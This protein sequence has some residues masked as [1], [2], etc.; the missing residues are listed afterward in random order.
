MTVSSESLLAGNKAVTRRKRAPGFRGESSWKVIARKS[1]DLL[2]ALGHRRSRFLD[3]MLRLV[4][5][6]TY[7]RKILQD[8]QIRNYLMEHHRETLKKIES[9]LG[10]LQRQSEAA[11][12]EA[13]SMWTVAQ[14]KK[15]LQTLISN[16]RNEG[17]QV[18]GHGK[19]PLVV[20]ISARAWKSVLRHHPELKAEL[21]QPPGNSAAP[22][23][24][25]NSTAKIRPAAS[26]AGD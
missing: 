1:E 17:P 7:F 4:S 5:F 20:V 3:D 24:S 23:T 11:E 22:R 6:M 13:I 15:Q 12:S 25:R 18:I 8:Q 9:T 10:Y 2:Q 19:R 26:A 16:V 14:A 21:G